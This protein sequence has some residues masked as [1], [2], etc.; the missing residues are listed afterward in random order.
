VTVAVAS[1][2]GVTVGIGTGV[3]KT[4]VGLLSPQAPRL[5][6][7]TR[8]SIT[9]IVIGLLPVLIILP[10]NPSSKIISGRGK[11]SLECLPQEI[12]TLYRGFVKQELFLSSGRVVYNRIMETPGAF[13]LQI[14]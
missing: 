3:S 11:H 7:N 4:W 8:H 12:P 9:I 5:K 10:L 1:G 14:G 2:N 13:Q 6:A